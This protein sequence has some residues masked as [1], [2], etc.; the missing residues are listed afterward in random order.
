MESAKNT[1]QLNETDACFIKAL[2]NGNNRICHKFFYEEI[3]GILHKIRMEVFHG[4]IDFDEMVSELYLYLSQDNWAKLAGFDGKNGCR[5][6]TW[7]IPVAWQYFMSIRERLLR[8]EKIDDNSSVIRDSLR[9]DVRI[10][11]AIDVNAV[12]SR[13]PNERY[14]EIIRL[15]LIEG[16][17]SQDVAD[18]LDLRVENIYNLKHRAINQF[19]E[20]YG[21]R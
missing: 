2:R 17:A 7:M 10:Q 18:M 5:L 21:R 20:L 19:I 3:G 14:A 8:T 16:Y 12:L 11:I 15:L 9:D 6:R 13:M 4:S 1:K